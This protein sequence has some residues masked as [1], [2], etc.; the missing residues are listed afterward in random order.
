M[1]LLR[2]LRRSLAI[3]AI[4]A[5]CTTG[6]QAAGEAVDL[7][8]RQWSFNGMFG[9]FDRAAAQRGFQVYREVCSSCHGVEYLAF[10]NLLDLGFSED[11]V[12]A[13]AAEYTVTDGPDD[14]GDMFERPAILSDRVPSPYPN[15]KAAAASNGGKAPPDLSLITKA[16]HDG[17]NYVYSLMQG[18]VEP[19]E[20]FEVPEGS[21]YN[22]FYP[23]H[24]IAMPQI[25]YG[26]DVEYMDGTSATL[27]Q[28]S[29]DLVQFL[30]WVAEPKLEERKQT[31]LASLIFLVIFS[32]IFYVYKKRIWSDLH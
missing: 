8:E 12:K 17:P 9:T 29:A 18:Y 22:V 26:D 20:D 31:G 11:M 23:G 1:T 14:N 19:E 2:T 6:A 16:R 27:D 3:A 5:A 7:L 24:V 30:H 10:R 4:G 32:G 21:Y 13:I 25:L 15:A 28:I